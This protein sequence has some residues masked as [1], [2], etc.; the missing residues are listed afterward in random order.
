MWVVCHEFVN[1]VESVFEVCVG[2]KFGC[3][4]AVISVGQVFCVGGIVEF[5]SF[6]NVCA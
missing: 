4:L 1:S 5:L 2:F 6:N 3:G